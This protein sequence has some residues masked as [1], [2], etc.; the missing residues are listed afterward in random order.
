MQACRLTGAAWAF[1]THANT[2]CTTCA[3]AAHPE[4]VAESIID[5]LPCCALEG[6]R[7]AV[8]AAQFRG[9]CY[10]LCPAVTILAKLLQYKLTI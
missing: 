9:P 1:M 7:Q 4:A 5:S 3:N 10:K 8:I 6:C 2:A